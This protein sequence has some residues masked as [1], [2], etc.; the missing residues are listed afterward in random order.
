MLTGV[1]LDVS[2]SMKRSIGGRVDQEGGSWAKSIF[3]VV[4]DLIKNDV[5][6][7]NHV[8]AIGVGGS[9]N[10]GVFDMLNTLKNSKPPQT[11]YLQ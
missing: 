3:K 4:D 8:F 11:L 6:Q 1:L 2:G 5:S 7:S 9:S 10:P